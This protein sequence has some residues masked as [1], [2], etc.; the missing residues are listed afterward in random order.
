MSFVL[1]FKTFT[2]LHTDLFYGC[3]HIYLDVGSNTGIQVRKLFQ[4]ELYPKGLINPYFDK[5]F[6]EDRLISVSR[7]LTK[8]FEETKRGSVKEVFSYYTE[9]PA[10]GEIVIIVDGKK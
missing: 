2:G 4:P 9:R 6:G 8:L 10:K 7:E 5:Y 3:Q 1:I